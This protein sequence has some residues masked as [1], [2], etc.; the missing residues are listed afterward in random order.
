MCRVSMIGVY[1]VV[2][3][4]VFMGD[5]DISNKVGVVR[6]VVIIGVLAAV[7]WV[8]VLGGAVL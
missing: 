1:G 5:R 4:S 8:G 2:G 6:V 7:C 3:V